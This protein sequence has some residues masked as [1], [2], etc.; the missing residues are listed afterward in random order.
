LFGPS[1][2]PRSSASGSSLFATSAS[3]LFGAANVGVTQNQVRQSTS[4]R[5]HPEL[6][7]KILLAVG[8][9]RL[10][11]VNFFGGQASPQ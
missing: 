6:K 3:T 10:T 4:L 1:E 5:S 2:P 11:F 7:L 9:I 8:V